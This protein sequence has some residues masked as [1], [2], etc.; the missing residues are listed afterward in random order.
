MKKAFLVFILIL[1]TVLIP[2]YAEYPRHVD[3]VLLEME[4]PNPVLLFIRYREVFTRISEREYVE[5]IDLLKLLE[6]V[7]SN[8][9]I[10]EDLVE[11]NQLIQFLVGKIELTESETST[12]YNYL[13]WLREDAALQ[14][15]MSAEPNLREGTLSLVNLRNLS[16][17]LGMMLDGAPDDL[18]AGLDDV[19]NLLDEIEAEINEGY[20]QVDTIKAEK[21]A[22]LEETFISA[23]LNNTSPFPGDRIELRGTLSSNVTGLGEKELEYSV[24]GSIKGD[25]VSHTDGEFVAIFTMPEI[26]RDALPVQVTYHP[27][28]GDES[29]YT[30]SIVGLS[31]SPRYLTPRLEMYMPESTFP[32]TSISVKFELSYNGEPLSGEKII[33]EAFD[34]DYEVITEYNGKS[35]IR[36]SVPNSIPNGTARLSCSFRG[37]GVYGPA[38]ASSGINVT[39]ID[40]IIQLNEFSILFSGKDAVISGVV[41]TRDSSIQNCPVKVKLEN[42]AVDTVTDTNGEFTVSI[43]TGLLDPSTRQSYIVSAFPEEAR[44]STATSSDGFI[45]INSLTL[46]AVLGFITLYVIRVKRTP[47]VYGEIQETES[48]VEIEK[49]VTEGYPGIYLEAVNIV[50]R[51]TN[52]RLKPSSTIRE[53]LIAIKSRLWGNIYDLFCNLSRLY[54]TWI[55][56]DRSNSTSLD[57]TQEILNRIRDEDE[58]KSS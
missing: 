2:V 48:P 47:R 33:F 20:Q 43:S 25:I 7:P 28:P 52:I 22:G 19:Q 53:Y 54:E 40:T 38:E 55:Y 30:P 57:K 58:E 12:A 5:A 3:P 44:Y 16:E 35:S 37:K 56:G 24:G 8:S 29:K 27:A 15:L 46:A 18:R 51:I 6:N 14:S 17:N 36:V 45:V 21:A 11:Y 23:V 42:I 34:V 4:N 49:T 26:Y 32:G 10:E 50:T 9:L 41:K 13:A 1:S 31:L 39:R